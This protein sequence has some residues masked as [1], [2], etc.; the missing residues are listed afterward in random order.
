MVGRDPIYAPLTREPKLADRATQQLQSLILSRIFKTGDRL[1]SERE[2]GQRLG[3]SRTVVR[4]A[5][6]A[7]TTKGLVEVRDGA[8][9]YVRSPS[10]D[11]VSE[12]LGMC[13]THLETGDV[14]SNH[15]L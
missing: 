10:T 1:P 5:L 13:V 7:L 12:L 6:R 11:L 3:V 15:I 14:T 4:E 8:G 9:A 2:L